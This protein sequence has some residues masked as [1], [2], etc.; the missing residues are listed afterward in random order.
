MRE[1]P[2]G[3]VTFLFTDVEGSTRLLQEL[4]DR[5]AAVLADHRRV[6]R[7]AFARH[8]GV[9]VDTQGDAFF[10]VFARAS[11]ALAAAKEA[12]EA[13]AGGPIR[14]RMAVHTGE[15]VLTEEG[16]IGIDVHRAARIAAA[17]HG[18]QILV[19]QSARDL[20]GANGL[21]DLG[22]HRLKDLTAP[23]RVYQ[24]GEDDF[25]PLK[26]LHRTNLPIPATPFLGRARELEDLGKLLARKD[27]R[28]VTLTGPGGSGKT[29]LALQASG[30]AADEYPDGVWWVPL[31]PLRDSTLVVVSVAHAL[32]AVGELSEH[33]GNRRLLL[34]LDNFEHVLPAA[35]EIGALLEQC[36]LLDAVVTS[37]ERLHLD[38]EW[39]YA[40]DPLHEG[41]AVELFVQRA[42]AVRKDFAATGEVREICAR[43]DH[44]PLA[45]ELAA[46]RMKVLSTTA[47]L[48]RLDVRLPILA[49]GPRN[50][51]GRQRT[52]RATIEWSHDLLSDEEKQL[53]RRLAVFAGGCTLDAAEAIC[54]ADLDLLASL[55]DKSLV[56]QA[57]DRF[58]MLETIR[59]YALEQ[60][61]SSAEADLFRTRHCNWCVDFAERAEPELF[62]WEQ[63]GWLDR[64]DAEAANFRVALAVALSRRDGELALRLTAAL[65]RFWRIRC[66]FGEGRRWLAEALD[67]DGSATG[68]LRSRTLHGAVELA[69]YQQDFDEAVRRAE[70]NLA[71]PRGS[72]DVGATVECLAF[73]S[74]VAAEVGDFQEA[75]RVG[76]S[77]AAMAAHADD[78]WLLS[79]VFNNLGEI[80]LM[81]GD[82]ERAGEAYERSEAHARRSGN[83][84][85]IANVTFNLGL[86]ELR[87]DQ[88][89]RAESRFGDALQVA[90]ELGD[91]ETAIDCLVGLAAVALACGD[92]KRAANLLGVAETA[93]ETIHA[94]L[95]T[96]ERAVYDRTR[97][98]LRG[99]LD[100]AT[101]RSHLDAGR[102]MDLDEAFEMI[103]P[104]A[105]ST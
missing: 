86:V 22:E 20:A 10:I 91:T 57:G 69:F 50:A 15:P 95:Q 58:W 71:L 82:V 51:P 8:G 83:P 19:S 30:A 23:E 4:G 32:E 12:R 53:F 49:E 105:K 25:P 68:T 93:R 17:G 35:P 99:S 37:R 54:D 74:R 59:E 9:E 70:Q 43:L 72:R 62:G 104:G 63:A 103:S 89:E 28:I 97:A 55:V 102:A 96:N 60:L 14:L 88:P 26:T 38:G 11:D 98:E 77:A 61:E 75:Q 92:A 42:G 45:I 44:L 34:L 84:Q 78:Q 31:A 24:L 40:V 80:N 18:G 1:L 21:R 66:Y 6:L 7:E 36:P 41:E 39:E 56:R 5:Y 27:A 13:L 52:L 90:R 48:D 64:L 47:L 65:W 79:R 87:R 73:L 100:D 33:I 67:A 81:R 16:Y 3:T 46:A 29:R 85:G 76:E 94:P 101:L 2:T